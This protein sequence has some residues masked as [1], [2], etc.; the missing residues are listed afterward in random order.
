MPKEFVLKHARPEKVIDILYVV[1][2]VDP[3]VAAARKWSCRF[4]SRSCS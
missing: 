1:L 2:G 4:S 3:Q